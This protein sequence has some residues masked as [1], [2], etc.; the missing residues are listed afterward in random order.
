MRS[1][2]RIED[3]N[4]IAEEKAR[5]ALREWQLDT[6]KALR[7]DAVKRSVSITTG[8]V[9]E[10]FIPHLPDFKY[11]PRDA[12][13]IGSPVDFIVFNGMTD[14]NVENIVFIEV[15]TGD[16]SLTTRE[17][18]VRDCIKNKNVVWESIRPR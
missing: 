17:R 6:E 10:H 3:A 5:V 15:K 12:R 14:G 7:A 13:F 18:K 1:N 16:S 2:Q 8:K 4:K 11:N 9:T